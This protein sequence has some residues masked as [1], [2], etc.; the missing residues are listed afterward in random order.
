M[1][2]QTYLAILM[3][4]K[5]III[6][7]VVVAL[8]A[9]VVGQLNATPTFRA[10]SIV[11]ISPDGAG[12]IDYGDLLY[13]EQLLNTYATLVH[14]DP[15][16][17]EVQTAIGSSKTTSALRSQIDVEFPP[18]TELMRLVVEDEDPVMAAN[19]A[20]EL[21]V[22][23][24]EQSRSTRAGRDFVLSIADPASVPSNPSRPSQAQLLVLAAVAGLIGGAALA[25]VIDATDSRLHTPAQARRAV[26][27]LPIIGTIPE[28]RKVGKQKTLLN[29]NSPIGESFRLLRT[30]LHAYDQINDDDAP[31]TF[32]VT[33][34]ESG[35]GKSTVAVHLAYTLAQ[36]GQRV[37][38]V[39]GD[40][41]Q[42]TVHRILKI[43]NEHGLSTIL[44]DQDQDQDQD[45]CASVV[46]PVVHTNLSII[47][48]GPP[49]HNPAELLGSEKMHKLLVDL[50]ENFD[51]VII[52]SPALLALADASI[53]ATQ[54]DRVV[55]VARVAYTREEAIQ[56]AY[57]HLTQINASVVGLVVNAVDPH[58]SYYYSRV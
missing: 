1:E 47:S 37:V 52:D 58:K 35:E 41:R 18:D 54:V 21:A 44:Q 32:L 9:V 29:G 4:R 3:R 11:R 45:T 17:T 48:S 27:A 39:D 28:T 19:A 20:N 40:M 10:A 8:I 55:M 33:S 26:A 16:L 57:E 25:F 49:P 51:R 14:S 53:L 31:R 15:I 12:A 2:I 34:A 46:Q 7:T 23:L 30:N 43:S 42:P 24:V 22:I 6:I 36:T 50:A 38:I 5:W 56:T 13:A